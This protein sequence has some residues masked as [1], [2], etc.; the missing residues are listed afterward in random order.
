[1]K[2][3]AKVYYLEIIKEAVDE[4]LEAGLITSNL[5]ATPTGLLVANNFTSLET[6]NYFSFRVN[7]SSVKEA[8]DLLELTCGCPEI[9]KQYPIRHGEK[10]HLYKLSSDP[11]LRFPTLLK[12]SLMLQ[13]ALQYDLQ[14]TTTHLPSKLRTEMD[15]ICQSLNHI[16]K[17]RNIKLV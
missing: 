15:S 4:L 3:L 6:F 17:C 10:Q 7:E 1:M 16:L 11:R 2:I 8:S 9:Q 5:E 13:A 12:P 14:E